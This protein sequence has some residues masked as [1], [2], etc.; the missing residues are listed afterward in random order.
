MRGW[1]CRAA[2]REDLRPEIPASGS[3]R[4]S[5]DFWAA[6]KLEFHRY[7]SPV[8]LLVSITHCFCPFFLLP[9]FLSYIFVSCSL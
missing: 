6:A 1:G 3:Q 5:G 4:Q 8:S 2:V 7:T 9:A